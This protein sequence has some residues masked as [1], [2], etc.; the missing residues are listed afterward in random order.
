MEELKKLSD[1]TGPDERQKAFAVVDS[2]SGLF[3]ALTFLDVY[4]NTATIRLH[5]GVPDVIR[6]HFATA[7][8][9]L[10]FSWFFYPFN[11]T[12]EFLAYVTVELALKERFKRE[13]RQSFRDLVK[14]AVAQGLVKDEGFSRVRERSEPDDSLDQ[15]IGVVPQ[16]VTSYTEILIDTMP[17]LRNTLAHGNPTLHPNGA[18]SVRLCAEFINQLF[19]RTSS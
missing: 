9:L 1:V 19:P 8:N 12:A 16:Q 17:Y 10:V 5:D 18:S 7:Q 2:T 11:V 14:L 6:S 4:Q 3:R 13:R 15:V